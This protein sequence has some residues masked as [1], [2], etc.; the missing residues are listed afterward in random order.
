MLQSLTMK[1]VALIESATLNFTEGLNVLSGET[2]SGKSVVVDSLN[3]VLGGKADKSM[4]RNGA[5]ACIL[6]AVF[7]VSEEVNGLLQ[8][9]GYEPDEDGVLVLWRKFSTE[10]KGEVKIN[11]QAASAS[12]LKK[13]TSR[14]VDVHGQSEHFTLLK[15]VAQLEL[16]DSFSEGADSLK[17]ALITPLETIKN[18][19]AQL[20]EIGGD[21]AERARRLDVLSFQIDELEQAE[22]KEGEEE[23]LLLRRKKLQSAEKIANALS[24]CTQN[25]LRDEGVMDGLRMATRA[26]SSISNFDPEYENLAER[27]S[28]ALSELDDISSFVSDIS[29]SFDRSEEELDAVETRLEHLRTIFRKYGGD[30]QAARAF[31]QRAKS[32]YDMISHSAENV[33]RLEKERD[34]ARKTAYEIAINLHKVR[35]VGAKKLCNAVMGEL[36]DLGMAR[37][38][39]EIAFSPVPSMD[40]MDAHLTKNGFDSIEIMFSPNLGEPVKPLAKIISGGEM[41]RFMLAIKAQTAQSQHLGTCV[42]DEI[43]T[44]ISGKNAR[45]VAEKFYKIALHMQVLAISHLPQI[46]AMADTSHLIYK[47]EENGKT[48]TKT[49][50][51]TSSEHVLEVV[52]LAGGDGEDTAVAHAKTMIATAKEYQ[53]SLRR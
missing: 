28:S 32:D 9:L 6:Q 27:L 38:V 51:L 48:Y 46:C 23:E 26:L 47:I 25:L 14:L 43:D 45:I 19:N 4:I 5:D 1:N 29:D 50:V 7:S 44:G 13:I 20:D 22:L 30:Y 17:R 8:D 35:E 10:G 2:G 36:Q 34:S 3:F 31:L 40:D 18:I 11:G 41:S 33:L 12:I 49:K 42:F 39:V 37:S 21:E 52:R 24:S 53:D 15:P 16:L